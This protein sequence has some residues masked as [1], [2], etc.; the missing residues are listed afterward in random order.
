MSRNETTVPAELIYPT[1]SR[2]G[3][4]VATLENLV[5][6]VARVVGAGDFCV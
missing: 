3:V 5:A 2:V 6:I 4:H 1:V